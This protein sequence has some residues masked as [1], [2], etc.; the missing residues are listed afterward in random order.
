MLYDRCNVKTED[1]RDSALL[2]AA[3]Q[4]TCVLRLLIILVMKRKKYLFEVA[5]FLMGSNSRTYITNLEDSAVH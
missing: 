5:V 3:R 2:S 1:Y 4:E